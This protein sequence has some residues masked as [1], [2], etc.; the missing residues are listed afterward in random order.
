MTRPGESPINHNGILEAELGTSS[1]PLRADREFARSVFAYRSLFDGLASPQR[2]GL[3]EEDLLGAW[4]A[5]ESVTVTYRMAGGG[6]VDLP[7][8]VPADRLYWYNSEFFRERYGADRAVYYYTHAPLMHGRAAGHHS[9]LHAIADVLQ[10]GAVV[11]T[12]SYVDERGAAIEVDYWP[13]LLMA[14]TGLRVEV[15]TLRGGEADGVLS[16]FIAPVVFEGTRGFASGVTFH[17]QYA[18]AS[19]EGLLA[20]AI[21]QG[22]EVVPTIAGPTADRLWQI[23]EG[24]FDALSGGHALRAGFDQ[25]SFMEALQDPEVVKVM[26][27][28]E[29]QIATLCIFVMDLRHCPWLNA[30][31]YEEHHRDAYQTGNILVF[32]AV[33]SDEGL[34]GASYAPGLIRVLTELAGMRGTDA[35]VTFE[36]N[37]VSSRYLPRIVQRAIGQARGASVSGLDEPVSRLAFN[38]VT[39]VP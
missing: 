29:G 38:A 20:D 28:V 8:I 5:E 33:V 21:A 36:C 4:P 31:Y 11:I 12:D 16:Q 17:E 15:S 13:H 37:G 30:D 14:E 26:R 9:A 3:S 22:V 24:P 27:R 34:R 32:T 6:S 25:R 18:T 10:R 23:Y 7:L 1:Q 39:A 2:L 35:L 19:D